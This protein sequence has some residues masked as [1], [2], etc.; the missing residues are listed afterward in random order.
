MRKLENS[1]K[2][3]LK[4]LGWVGTGVIHLPQAKD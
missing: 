3:D 2:M 4:K 1:F